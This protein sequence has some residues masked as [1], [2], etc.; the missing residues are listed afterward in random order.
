MGVGD[1]RQTNLRGVRTAELGMGLAGNCLDS[2]QKM[3]ATDI[4]GER[5][6]TT[7]TADKA[8][9]PVLR[10]RRRILRAVV[11]LVV[12]FVRQV[13]VSRLFVRPLLLGIN[14]KPCLRERGYVLPTARRSDLVRLKW[15]YLRKAWVAPDDTPA[16]QRLD[17]SFHAVID[18]IEAQVAGSYPQQTDEMPLP[19]YDWKNGNPEEFYQR[20]I[21][22]PMPVVLRGYALQTEA[23]KRWNFEYIVEKCGDVEVTLTGTESDWPGPLKSVRDPAVY[24]ANADAP[25][26]AFPEL[27]EELSIPQLKPYIKRNYT[28]SQFFVGQK[29][30]GSGYH[31]AGIWNFFYMIEGQKKWYFVDPELTWMMYPSIHIGVLA[32]SSLVYFPGSSNGDL[33]KLY[34]YCPRYSVTLNPGDVLLNP[35]WFW[36][37]VENITPTSVAVATRW[38]AVRNDLTFYE[39]NRVLSLLAV[40]N[41]NFPRFLFE[42]ITSPEGN[43]TGGLL[44]QGAAKFDED[45]QFGPSKP[46]KNQNGRLKN[47]YT[48]TVV[49]KIRKRARW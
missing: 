16:N 7:L 19:E 38:D 28:F 45:V 22:T 44:S 11:V 8:P 9:A 48:G 30:T 2:I 18:R 43:D 47:S 17:A 29:A 14:G 24:C 6:V 13:L 34:K 4:L 49:D 32:F 12:L 27:V 20:Y 3:D 40:F 26:K 33:Y 5:S 46:V 31:C 21:K 1:G 42:F 39:I 37:A 35:P 25:F 41:P 15:L 10:R 23:A 36:H